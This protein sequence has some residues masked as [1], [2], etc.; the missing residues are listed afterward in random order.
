MNHMNKWEY[1]EPANEYAKKGYTVLSYTAR[2]FWES[3]GVISMANIPDQN[4]ISTMITWVIANTNADPDRIGLS[5]ISY[6]GGLSL[7]GAAKDSR[8]KSIVS[9]SCWV[10]K[11]L[12][13]YLNTNDPF[14]I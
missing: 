6:G 11:Y 7:L 12:Y 13:I 14:L 9:M 5:G 4:D 8:V 3:G 1:V 10:N 2:G